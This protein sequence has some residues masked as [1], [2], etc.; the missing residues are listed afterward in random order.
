MKIDKTLMKYRLKGSIV[1]HLELHFS[2]EIYIPNGLVKN[3]V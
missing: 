3:K 2:T 1:K